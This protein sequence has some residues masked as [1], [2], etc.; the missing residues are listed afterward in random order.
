MKRKAKINLLKKIQSG[1]LSAEDLLKGKKYIVYKWTDNTY[2]CITDDVSKSI[3][4][5]QFNDLKR[6]LRKNDELIHIIINGGIPRNSYPPV[7]D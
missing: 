3:T 4:E 5:E 2:N 7:I 6:S 1:S